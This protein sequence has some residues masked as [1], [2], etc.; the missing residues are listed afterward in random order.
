MSLI[1]ASQTLC[2]LCGLEKET[3][4]DYFNDSSLKA[5]LMT[6]LPLEVRFLFDKCSGFKVYFLSDQSRE[7]ISQS[8][9]LRL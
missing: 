6:F 3:L 7:P 9:V 4:S 5:D 1:E 2:R 8:S